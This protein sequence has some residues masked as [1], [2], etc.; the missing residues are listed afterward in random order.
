MHLCKAKDV[1]GETQTGKT[2]MTK[3]NNG[4][5][6]IAQAYVVLFLIIILF[7]SHD[8]T[9]DVLNL[10]HF[11]RTQ[12]ENEPFIIRANIKNTAD[13]PRTYSLTLYVDGDT[14]LT[15]ES[16]FDALSTQT[17]TLTIASPP[18]GSAVRVYAEAVD[19]ETGE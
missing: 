10:S 7:N 2:E 19:L 18:L 6:A 3:H 14:V 15:S 11:P 4:V 12:K 17:S 5:K 1:D 9:S 16:T 8:Q 13:E